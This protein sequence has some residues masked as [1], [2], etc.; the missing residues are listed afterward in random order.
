M[1]VWPSGVALVSKSVA[2]LPPAPGLLSM[3]YVL[4]Q[5]LRELGHHDARNCVG[6]AA[7]GKAHQNFDVL[8]W[9]IIV[10]CCG[11]GAYRQQGLSA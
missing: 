4:L 9:K 6:A 7:W 2:M 1:M 3:T 5:Q 11:L 8:R 10:R